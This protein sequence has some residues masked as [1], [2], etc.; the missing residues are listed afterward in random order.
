MTER[1][2]S[3]RSSS[4]APGQAQDDHSAVVDRIDQATPATGR[5]RLAAG[6]AGVGALLVGLGAA[7]GVAAG[8]DAPPAYTSW[9]L[10]VLLTLLPPAVAA[11]LLA[12][13]HARTSAAVLAASALFAPGR[14][15]VDLQVAVDSSR[16][17]TPEL[18]RQHSLAPL[19]PTAGLWL[20]VAGWLAVLAAG[21]LAAAL[22]GER[23]EPTEGFDAS[24]DD[25]R[26]QGRLA[27]L[28]FVGLLAGA[29]LLGPSFASTDPYLLGVGPLDSP[30]TALVGGLLL[31][32]A[33][34][35]GL[36]LAASAGE[37]AAR[38]GW[39]LGVAAG[40]AGVTVPPIVAGVTV[41]GLDVTWGPLT[42]L[43]V[44]VVLAVLSGVVGRTEPASADGETR[45]DAAVSL[46]GQSRSQLAAGVLGLLAALAALGGGLGPQLDVPVGL[47]APDDYAARLL[48]PAAGVLVAL[49][50][51]LLFRGAAAA[52]RPAFLVALAVLPLAAGGQLDAAIT[53]TQFGAIQPGL[54][55]WSTVLALVLGVAAACCAGLAGAA[56]R[57][58]V[59]LT[60]ITPRLDFAAPAFAAAL[61]TIG[62]F[63]LPTLRAPGYVAPG[64]WSDFRTASWGML[65]A[66]VTVLV[67]LALGTVSRPPRAA[68]LLLGAAA[69]LLV[70]ALEAPLTSARTPGSSVGPGTWL[71][72]AAVAALVVSAVL[73]A[74]RSTS[75]TRGA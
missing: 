72:L 4:A 16:A 58:E 8:Q 63:G 56:E 41:A 6:I 66:L 18:T 1:A 31:A 68:A 38:R 47:A 51:P 26:K 20:L 60:G 54:G 74:R 23:A 53:A 2:R 36:A 49:S 59:D 25:R 57:E 32:V 40:L 55:V 69:V 15:L 64:L 13:G 3:T 27:G 10:L 33:A 44:A 67:A 14:I 34:P 30:A 35:L 48:G 24:D 71:A 9:P 19:H 5:L 22:A 45:R 29:G 50:L 12:R 73:A 17:G 46:P 21:V 75:A 62:A 61:F 37:P 43:A 52:V 11:G 7:L 70:R 42:A 28:L 39:L 65:L